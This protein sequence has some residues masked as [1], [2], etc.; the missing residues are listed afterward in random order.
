MVVGKQNP[1]QSPD[2]QIAFEALGCNRKRTIRLYHAKEQTRGCQNWREIKETNQHL[3]PY[4]VH[5]DPAGNTTIP[6]L[7]KTIYYNMQYL[8]SLRVQYMIPHSQTGS[9]YSCHEEKLPNQIKR[10]MTNTCQSS[11]TRSW[12]VTTNPQTLVISNS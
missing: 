12:Y 2:H 9:N 3:Q 11:Q 1:R 6:L 8:L 7:N 4:Q 5:H 10:L